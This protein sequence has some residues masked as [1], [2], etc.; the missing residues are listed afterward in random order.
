MA[1]TGGLRRGRR[2]ASFQGYYL[3]L[4]ASVPDS[5]SYSVFFTLLVATLVW[6]PPA[7]QKYQDT[8]VNF[9]LTSL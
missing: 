4:C 6:F 3:N 1:A 7:H 2:G 8:L 9:R 5:F